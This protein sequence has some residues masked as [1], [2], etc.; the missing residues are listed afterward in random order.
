MLFLIV[1]AATAIG[2]LAWN[3][4]SRRTTGH[5]QKLND[6]RR[7]GSRIVGRG[8]FVDGGRRF[9]VALAL[10]DTA[11]YYESSAVQA[12]LDLEWIEE[13]DYDTRLATGRTIASG[14]VMRLR[15][16]RQV[17]EFVLP[18]DS[19]AAW[20]TEFPAHRQMAALA[21][22]AQRLA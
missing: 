15:C 3:L 6:R 10:T 21:A 11:F 16:H 12:S 17:F 19:V 1:A 7:T 22:P 20:K 4:A 2:L 8:E 9:D 14:Q 18:D 5:L 13:L